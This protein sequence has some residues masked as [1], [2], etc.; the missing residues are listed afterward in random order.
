MKLC[1]NV[2]NR[3]RLVWVKCYLNQIS[4]AAVIAKCLAGLT[5]LR[6]TG[7]RL[8]LRIRV[9]MD[10]DDQLCLRLTLALTLTLTLRDAIKNEYVMLRISC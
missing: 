9:N 3:C 2:R 7:Q 8:W 6:P 5:F 4:V 1:S 10:G